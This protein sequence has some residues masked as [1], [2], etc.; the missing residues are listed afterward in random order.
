MIK[1]HMNI[2]FGKESNTFIVVDTSLHPLKDLPRENFI[3]K[4]DEGP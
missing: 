4:Y 3:S 2:E 1:T